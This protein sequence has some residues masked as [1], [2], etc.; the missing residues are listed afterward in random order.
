MGKVG[1]AGGSGLL[2]SAFEGVVVGPAGADPVH[3]ET[4]AGWVDVLADW[5]G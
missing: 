4:F 2:S 1:V 3:V 5:F